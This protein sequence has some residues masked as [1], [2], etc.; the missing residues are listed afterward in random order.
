MRDLENSKNVNPPSPN[1]PQ[2]E[3]RDTEVGV[4]DGS[5][6]YT[7]LVADLMHGI[8]ELM[9]YVGEAPDNT[10]DGE[11]PIPLV[12]TA[13]NYQL[14]DGLAKFIRL[15]GNEGWRSR[16]N[17]DITGPVVA[18][19]I[20]K[21]GFSIYERPPQLVE[22]WYPQVVY[23]G[24][25]HIDGVLFCANSVVNFVL[26][27]RRDV[28]GNLDYSTGMPEEFLTILNSF[29]NELI[30]MAELD[31]G[32]GNISAISYNSFLTV[33]R[34][35]G[36]PGNG[37]GQTVEPLNATSYKDQAVFLDF[38]RAVILFFDAYSTTFTREIQASAINNA[39]C[40]DIHDDLIYLLSG[41]INNY[42]LTVIDIDSLEEVRSFNVEFSAGNNNLDMSIIG[43]LLH[44]VGDSEYIFCDLYGGGQVVIDSVSS[45][46]NGFKKPVESTIGIHVASRIPDT[47]NGSN[48]IKY[49]PRKI[50][51]R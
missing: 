34:T 42:L 5:A 37:P 45:F 22:D 40:F 15:V 28:L 36:T 25:A 9:N 17:G 51:F 23:N 29:R 27:E 26:I 11:T 4:E 18:A 38:S 41:G 49:S 35:Y 50:G 1:F 30:L 8:H 48:V 24:I 16:N 6:V 33:K 19:D 10:V 13:H 20:R 12:S 39:Q 3:L 31:T 47:G 46:V 44:I 43:G 32:S 7:R 21:N 14:L 2:G